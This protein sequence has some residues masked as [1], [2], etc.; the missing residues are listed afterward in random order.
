MHWDDP[1]GWD[2]EGGGKGVLDGE[3]ICT[4]Y[5]IMSMYGKTQYN[6]VISLQ[7]NKYINFFKKERKSPCLNPGYSGVAHRPGALAFLGAPEKGWTSDLNRITGSME[8][9]LPLIWKSCLMECMPL[10][11]CKAPSQM[12][13]SHF[14]PLSTAVIHNPTNSSYFLILNFTT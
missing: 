3:H 6:T 13:K 1:G 9:F 11:P 7:L 10:P 12:I 8:M 5:W 4:C 14:S 2:G